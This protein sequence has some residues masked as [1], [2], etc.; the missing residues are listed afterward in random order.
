MAGLLKKCQLLLDTK[1]GSL[2]LRD[3]LQVKLD[4]INVLPDWLR[5]QGKVIMELTAQQPAISTLAENANMYAPVT[6]TSA[7]HL[8]G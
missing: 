5:D 6:D 7:N 4:L 1:L 3:E 8:R 2:I